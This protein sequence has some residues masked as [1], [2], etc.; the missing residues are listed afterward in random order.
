MEGSGR[1]KSVPSRTIKLS[2]FDSQGIH[3]TWKDK[4]EQDMAEAEMAKLESAFSTLI[5]STGDPEVD[6]EGLKKTPKRA[7]KAFLYFTKGYEEDLQS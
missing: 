5:K 6:R 7:A 1:G 4:Q 2:K 3:V